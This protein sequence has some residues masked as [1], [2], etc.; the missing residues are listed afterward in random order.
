[1]KEKNT[2]NEAMKGIIATEAVI[3]VMASFVFFLLGAL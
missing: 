2:A 3:L 1:M